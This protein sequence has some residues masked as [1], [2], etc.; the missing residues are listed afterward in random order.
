M[1]QGVH[2]SNTPAPLHDRTKL[3]QTKRNAGENTQHKVINKSKKLKQLNSYGKSQYKTTAAIKQQIESIMAARLI[4]EGG[5]LRI[6]EAPVR[7][8][9][10]S[11]IKSGIQLNTKHHRDLV[12]TNAARKSRIE[13]QKLKNATPNATDGKATTT[14]KTVDGKTFKVTP[15]ASSLSKK[16]YNELNEH[17]RSVFEHVEQMRQHI[18]NEVVDS[19]DELEQYI[20]LGKD[21]G[22]DRHGR[23]SVGSKR[24]RDEVDDDEEEEDSDGS[25][26][27]DDSDDSGTEANVLETGLSAYKK[28]L[29]S[30]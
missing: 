29:R 6:V 30:G 3:A 16:K 24:W 11:Y 28:K 27:E 20:A 18:S 2:R 22:L 26:S 14:K 25:E 8:D 5:S 1:V 23:S 19:D 17:Q 10:K 9:V 21:D 15:A 7:E 13:K 4:H 12:N